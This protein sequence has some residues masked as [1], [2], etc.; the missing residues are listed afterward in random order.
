MRDDETIEE[1]AT[2]ETLTARYTEEAIRLVASNVLT[3][4][5]SKEGFYKL[6]RPKK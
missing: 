2:Q 1:P 6:S 3:S 5:F 4:V